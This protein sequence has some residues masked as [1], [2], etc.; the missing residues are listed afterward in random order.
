MLRAKGKDPHS[1]L[2]AL[3]YGYDI[4]ISLARYYLMTSNG[5]LLQNAYFTNR[6]M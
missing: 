5:T 3:Q 6:K 4:K 1:A 2:F